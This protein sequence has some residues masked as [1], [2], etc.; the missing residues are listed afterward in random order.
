[1]EFRKSLISRSE[2]LLYYVLKYGDFKSVR[3]KVEP[4]S[5][6]WYFCIEMDTYFHYAS[7]K[8]PC[9]FTL[10]GCAE[11]PREVYIGHHY[12]AA[13]HWAC[14]A[15]SFVL[16]TPPPKTPP[17]WHGIPKE[18]YDAYLFARDDHDDWVVIIYRAYTE[19]NC[20][21]FW[22]WNFSWYSRGGG[23]GGW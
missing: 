14:P 4:H 15:S 7:R 2:R 12:I 9:Y 5:K 6:Y 20:S 3:F 13:I 10:N 23:G 22:T 8:T 18:I 21:M 17:K 19:K 1:M 16:S 11:K